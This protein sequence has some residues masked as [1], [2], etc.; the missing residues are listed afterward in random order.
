MEYPGYGLYRNEPSDSETIQY[1]ANIVYDFILNSMKYDSKDVILFGR[2]MGSGPSTLLAAN[3]KP[4]SLILLSP[5]TSLKNAVKSL[6][7]SVASALVKERFANYEM[8]KK[9]TC[10]VLIVHG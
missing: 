9:V 7:G 10:P 5:Y 8:I 3:S 4:A 2:S 1:N 6:F